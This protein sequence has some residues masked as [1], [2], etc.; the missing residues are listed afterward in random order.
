MLTA[1]ILRP[2]SLSVSDLDA[3]AAM[4]AAHPGF[5]N[6]LFGPQWARTVGRVRAD[7]HVAVLKRDGVTVGF[8]AHHRRPAGLGRPIGA[9]FADLHA[10]IAAPGSSLTLSE[11]VGAAGLRAYRFTGLMDPEKRA[12]GVQGS[13]M[14]HVVE[15]ADGD[16]LLELIRSRNPK[17]F[18]NWRRLGNKLDREG[19][20]SELV[21]HDASLESFEAL[22]GWKRAQLRSSGLHDVYRPGWVQQ[23]MR[24]LM[25]D[26]DPAFG[27][28]LV[29]LYV[30]GRPVAGEFGVR[31]GGCFHPW[32][33]AYD[34][35]WAAYSPGILLQLRIIERMDQLGLRRYDLGANSDHYKAPMSTSL[36]EVR[37]GAAHGADYRP[38]LAHGWGKAMD[39]SR[40][41]ARIHQRW[42]QIDAVETTALGRMQGLL[43]AVRDG[44]KRLSRTEASETSAEG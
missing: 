1:D 2:E 7:A 30:A 39:R 11:A 40:V 9:P 44:P 27:G 5:C 15:R 8:L 32:I 19:G 33:A 18:K 3:W 28:L 20:I 37:S 29:T 21:A 17:R 43:S 12:G 26:P 4:R 41:G 31:E 22:L 24:D 23:L 16:D 10:L 25:A 13:A 14:A 35:A 38:G 6:P 36:I 34:P 42:E